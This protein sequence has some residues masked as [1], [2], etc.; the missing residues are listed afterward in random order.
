MKK[1]LSIVG[2]FLFLL[3]LPFIS[4]AAKSSEVSD[5]N[6]LKKAIED[7]DVD[8]ITLNGNI[9]TTEKLNITHALTIDGAGHTLTYTGKFGSSEATTNTTWGSVYVLQVYKTTATIKNIKLTGANAALLVNG[10]TV[11]LEG[12]IDVS[13]NGFGGIELGKGTDVTEEPKLVLGENTKLVNSGEDADSNPTVWVDKANATISVKGAKKTYEATEGSQVKLII[14]DIKKICPEVKVETEEDSSVTITDQ[15]VTDVF[16]ES[17]KNDE[18][19]KDLL[20]SEGDVT[21]ELVAKEAKVDS[22]EE[23]LFEGALTE[24]NIGGYLDI[25]I[26]VTKDNQEEGKLTELSKTIQLSA[27]L[28]EMPALAEGFSRKYYI[29]REHNGVVQRL[30]ATLS[31]DG[32][33]LVFA[34]DKFSKYAIVYVDSKIEEQQSTENGSNPNTYD[35]SISYMGLALLSLGVVIVSI[36]KLRN[37]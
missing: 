2:V 27:K 14:E 28:P 34:S 12:T 35:A 37:N 6:E 15:G 5:F 26:L 10:S 30:D 18:K 25:E 8:S 22:D 36:R 24:G 9:E 33:S 16:N 1:G 13:G 21:I 31:E 4:V 19:L 32:K 17:L 29:L 11:T 3:V 7:A 23:K 20:G